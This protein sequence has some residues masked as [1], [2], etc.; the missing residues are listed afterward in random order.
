MSKVIW[1]IQAF[2]YNLYLRKGKKFLGMRVIFMGTPAFA[3]ASLQALIEAG[4][5]IVA[6]VTAPDRRAGRG[7]K[8]SESAV[9]TFA[10][11]HQIPVLQPEK[12]RDPAFIETL[13]S[14][15]ADLQVV[16]AFRMLPEVV[17]NMP[18][19]G[20]LNLHASLLPQ[21]RGAAPIN[22][23]L[24]NGESETGVTTFLLKHEIDT[25]DILFS[26]KTAIGPDE[27]AGSLH[28][29]L[30]E[31]GAKLVVKTVQGIAEDRVT[32]V[33]QP[34]ESSSHPLRPAPKIFK[35]DTRI[36]W[37]RPVDE[38]YNFIRGLSPYPGAFTSFQ[39]KSVKLYKSQKRQADQNHP[40]PAP[41]AHETDGKT[42]LRFAT[43]DGW[44]DVSE[45]QL[46]GKR[47]MDV[48]EFLR[49]LR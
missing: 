42:Y 30:M 44:I 11:K 21:Y 12:L 20:T 38:V 39:G 35:E 1:K 29:R 49:G 36:N 31:I 28:D 45:L 37:D 24:I 5:Q 9:K 15:Q 7:Q 4:V 10:V 23:A 17:W 26:E 19:R 18:P 25:G 40:L 6:V 3:V 32:P 48:K 14:Y 34:K 8:L 41:G 46:E 27:D 2:Q 16:V 33:P 47:K 43:A 22:H 13:R